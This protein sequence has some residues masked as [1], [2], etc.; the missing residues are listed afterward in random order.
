MIYREALI[1]DIPQIQVVRHT[2]KENT[3]SNPA[4]VTDA[5]CE[6]FITRRGKGWVCEV[7]GELAGFS[8]V[9]LQEHN[10]WALFLRPEFEGKGIGK[11]LHRLMMDWYFEQTR[12]TVWLGTSPNTRAEVFY[13]R[14][15][16]QKTGMVNKDEVKFE[17][18]YA[19]WLGLTT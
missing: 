18:T 1:T 15:G 8:I 14:Q 10:I 4:L 17:M 2:V 3:L 16:W 6:D 19:D 13:T 12:E 7:A 5:D 11:A 9:D